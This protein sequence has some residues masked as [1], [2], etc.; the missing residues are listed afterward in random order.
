MILTCVSIANH[1]T[2]FHGKKCIMFK[3]FISNELKVV[4]YGI[5]Y[6]L[7]FMMIIH[8]RKEMEVWNLK[9]GHCAMNKE[10][11]E[12]PKEPRK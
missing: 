10:T 11:C 8:D 1:F 5:L 3:V 4:I 12:W 7:I 2:L 6:M 9:Y